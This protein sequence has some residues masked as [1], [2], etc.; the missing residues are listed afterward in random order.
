MGT[1]IQC[2]QPEG[3]TPTTTN[4]TRAELAIMQNIADQL[5]RLPDYTAR[6]R[7]LIW[8]AEI[9]GKDSR[10]APATSA[11]PVRPVRDEDDDDLAIGSASEWFDNPSP[12]VHAL[13]LRH[14]SDQP[15]TSIMDVFVSDFQKLTYDWQEK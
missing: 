15:I 12:E 13:R 5:N 1:M 9:F 3:G 10:P 4:S 7:V 14:D 11:E 6:C 2:K 8:A